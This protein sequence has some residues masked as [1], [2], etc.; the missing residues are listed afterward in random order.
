MIGPW[1]RQAFGAGARLEEAPDAA[2]SC[3]LRGWTSW[4]PGSGWSDGSSRSIPRRGGDRRPYPLSVMLRSSLRGAVLQLSEPGDGRDLLYEVESVTAFLWGCGPVVTEALPDET[5][6]LNFRASVGA[7]HGLGEGLF[8]GDQCA[9]LASR[10]HRL[11]TGTIVDASIIEAPSSTRL[12]PLGPEPGPRTDP[13]M[14]SDEEGQAVV[15]RDEGAH[16]GGRRPRVWRHSLR[17][18]RPTQAT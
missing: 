11:R 15:F 1:H 8:A 18:R 9:L 2:L 10:G 14:R 4:F 17:R 3:S 12:A 6:I 13:E 7:V 16:R 5:T